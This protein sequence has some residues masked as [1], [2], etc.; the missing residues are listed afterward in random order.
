[1]IY[2]PQV[3][4]GV[5]PHIMWSMD[6]IRIKNPGY[7]EFQHIF[8]HSEVLEEARR[9]VFW[10]KGFDTDIA[11]VNRIFGMTIEEHDDQRRD[12]GYFIQYRKL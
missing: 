11:S 3:P 12:P 5:M 10:N 2:V 9:E 4:R 6:Q 7:I 8:I 1:M